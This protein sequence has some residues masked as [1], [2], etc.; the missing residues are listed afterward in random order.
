MRS[1]ARVIPIRPEVKD[2]RS[3]RAPLCSHWMDAGGRLVGTV[4]GSTILCLSDTRFETK[5][6]GDRPAVL[7][8]VEVGREGG[9]EGG[10]GGRGGRERQREE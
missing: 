3:K 5:L 4:Q 2:D 9:R 10:E 6:S 7:N 1:P 8:T